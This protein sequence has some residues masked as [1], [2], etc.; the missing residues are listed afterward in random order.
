MMGV[1]MAFTDVP[2]VKGSSGILG[3]SEEMIHGKV[4]QNCLRCGKC[5]EGCPMN[6]LPNVIK[7]ALAAGDTEKLE[8]LNVADCIQC[9]SC[10]YVCP[11]EQNPLQSV[12]TAKAKLLKKKQEVKK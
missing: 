6:L 5:V 9:G 7:D 11:A 4:K 2:V 1:S 3:F 10:A 12:R 8:K